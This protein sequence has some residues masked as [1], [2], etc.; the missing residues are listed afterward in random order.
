MKAEEKLKI[1]LEANEFIQQKGE[2]VMYPCLVGGTGSGKSS[3]VDK[4]AHELQKT[5]RIIPLSQIL[6]EYVY[7]IPYVDE[8]TKKMVYAIPDWVSYNIIFF[9]ELHICVDQPHKI[10]PIQHILFERKLHGKELNNIFIFGA[11]ITSGDGFLGYFSSS[12]ALAGM[13]ILIPVFYEEAIEYVKQKHGWEF[14][15]L[16]DLSANI[17]SKLREFRL[18]FTLPSHIEY[19]GE[20]ALFLNEKFKEVEEKE[21]IEKIKS[22]IGE[23]FY[24]LPALPPIEELLA[25]EL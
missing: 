9:D 13:L 12:E 16:D 20:F 24:Y 11:M 5:L 25:K 3:I 15:K 21:R 4:L 19:V 8:E 22:I 23:I 17:D 6:P 1:I 18:E 7:G 10:A 14:L 2:R